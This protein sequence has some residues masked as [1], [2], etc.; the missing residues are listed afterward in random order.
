MGRDIVLKSQVKAWEGNSIKK[1]KTEEDMKCNYWFIQQIP[2]FY[3][4][5]IYSKLRRGC[6]A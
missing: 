1:Y 2:V 4:P 5:R 3:F 6:L